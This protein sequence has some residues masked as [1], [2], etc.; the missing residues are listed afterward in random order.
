MGPGTGQYSTQ[1]FSLAV[2]LSSLFVYNQMGGI[3]EAA[4]DKLSLVTEMTKHIRVRSENSNEADLASFTPSFL[5][6]LRDFYLSLEEEGELVTARQYLETALRSVS[7]SSSAAQAKNQIRDSIKALFPDRDCLTLVRPMGDEKMLAKLETLDPSQ[8]RPEFQEGLSELTKAIFQKA[9]PKRMNNSIITGPMLAAL[10]E[11]YVDAINKGAVPT[12]ATAWQGVA[13]AES[14]RAADAAEAAYQAAFKTDTPAD[15]IA[16]GREYERALSIG[17]RTFREVAVGEAS[18]QQANEKRFQDRVQELFKQFKEQRLTNAALECEQLINKGTQQLT[19]VS[20][21]AGVTPEILQAEYNKF[22][23]AYTK[24]TAAFGTTKWDRLNDFRNKA[25]AGLQQDVQRQLAQ[26]RQ[27][28]VAAERQKAQQAEQQR[29]Q[30]EARAAD[31][32]QQVQ[33]LQA[34]VDRL[35]SE[36]SRERSSKEQH[37]SRLSLLEKQLQD[38]SSLLDA[39]QREMQQ[40]VQRE[41]HRGEAEQRAAVSQLDLQL[42]QATQQL[43]DARKATHT[44]QLEVDS[45]NQQLTSASSDSSDWVS[46]FQKAEDGRSTAVAQKDRLE[47]DLRAQLAHAEQ[48]ATQAETRL[49]QA[50]QQA[51][52][53]EATLTR[54]RQSW[55][56]RLQEAQA[57]ATAAPAPSNSVTPAPM[58][59]D[60]GSSNAE[61]DPGK[62]TIKELKDWLSEHDQ[63]EKLWE[64]GQRKAKKPEYAECVRVLM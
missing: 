2:L 39:V 50:Q 16:L 42:Q 46:K 10:T 23:Q 59:V 3:D 29:Q 58:A 63:Q 17:Q 30:V 8:F 12:I 47:R 35:H 22:E 40:A 53:A 36:L 24:A 9:Q 18:I 38:K 64:L 27:Q 13:E 25:F 62:M 56:Q 11:A 4:L 21:Q 1:I 33:R 26:A 28:E 34:E 49:S 19:E 43:A 5:W 60:G 31:L 55:G 20:R 45:L 57:Q 6:L 14:R 48:R 44:A 51:S 15:E 7:G 32:G 54:E 41:K 37:T 52:T 61:V